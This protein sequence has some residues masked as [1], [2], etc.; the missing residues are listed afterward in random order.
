MSEPGFKEI[1]GI[2]GMIAFLY[3]VNQKN[4]D[5]ITVQT[6]AQ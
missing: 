3:Q 6:K 5:I 2:D 4:Q 1:F